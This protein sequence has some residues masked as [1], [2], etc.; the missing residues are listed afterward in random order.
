MSRSN[1]TDLINPAVRFFDWSGSDG[2]VSYFDK[3]LGEKGENVAVEMPF[4]FMVLDKVSQVTG[5]V[6]RDGKYEGFWSN[7]VKNLKTQKFIVRSKQGVEVQGLY[8][9][10]KGH[11]GVKFM[12]GLYVAFH[13]EEKVLQIGYLKLRGAALTAWIDFTKS[14][15]NIYEGAF[16]ITDKAKKKKGSNAYFEPVFEHIPKITEESETA[17]QDLDRQLQEYLT[18][19][20]AQQ[21][22]AEVEREYSGSAPATGEEPFYANEPPMNMDSEPDMAPDDDIDHAF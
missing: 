21:G 14:H 12:T 20:F 3:T 7:A 10:I 2:H 11:T 18:A 8:E 9:N 17:A 6:D 19:Y 1:Q 4:R 13:D 22:I 5:G 16:S 15:R